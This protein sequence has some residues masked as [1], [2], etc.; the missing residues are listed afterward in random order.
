MAEQ[1][2]ATDLMFS[3]SRNSS[4]FAQEKND[5]THMAILTPCDVSRSNYSGLL[6]NS[7]LL[8]TPHTPNS[9]TAILQ[10][11]P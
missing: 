8:E 3:T 6:A 9:K 5:R 7:D 10:I 2:L 4:V 11:P 1:K